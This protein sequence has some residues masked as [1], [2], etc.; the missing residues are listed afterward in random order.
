[1]LQGYTLLLLWELHVWSRSENGV[2][3]THKALK[4]VFMETLCVH[5]LGKYVLSA[6]YVKALCWKL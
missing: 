3:T 4:H 1:M 6:Y 2:R 5:T